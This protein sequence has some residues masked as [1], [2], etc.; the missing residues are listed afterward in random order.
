MCQGLAPVPGEPPPTTVVPFNSQISTCPVDWLIQRMSVLPSPLKSPVP[1]GNQSVV[2]VPGEPPPMTLAPS[3]SQIKICPLMLLYQMMS[4]LPSLL[5]S[6]VPMSSQ[7]FIGGTVPAEPLAG[8]TVVPFISQI[9]TCPVMVLCQRM[10][11]LWS[12]LKSPVAWTNQPNGTTPIE[13]PPMTF[14]PFSSQITASPVLP[15]RQRMSAKPSPL[16]SRWPTMPQSVGT[17]PSEP[18]P[19][20]LAPFINQ[21]TVSPSAWCQRIS[22]R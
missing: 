13:P 15:L 18:P 17:V 22:L 2:A 11:P 10:S 19:I 7:L 20:A 8:S 3:I 9:T 14:V 16:K 1:L 5:T 4:A 6:P 12:P 21:I